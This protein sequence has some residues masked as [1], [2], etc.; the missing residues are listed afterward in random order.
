M[1]ANATDHFAEQACIQRREQN[2]A[3]QATGKILHEMKHTQ[4]GPVWVM[5]DGVNRMTI[6]PPRN[7]V[8]DADV[9]GDL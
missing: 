8:I 9:K 7:V 5:S 4:F 1:N 2:L 3:K 6:H